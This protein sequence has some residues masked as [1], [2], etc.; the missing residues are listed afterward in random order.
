MNYGD[1][2]P[3]IDALITTW[4]VLPDSVQDELLVSVNE[5]DDD[6][7]VALLDHVAKLEGITRQCHLNE[8]DDH[9]GEDGFVSGCCRCGASMSYTY[10]DGW[11]CTMA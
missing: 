8:M 4:S 10:E 9:E 3:I 5:L 1:N 2:Q 11:N 7:A 6:I